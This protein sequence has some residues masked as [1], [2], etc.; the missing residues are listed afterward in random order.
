MLSIYT[1][2]YYGKHRGV[3][4]NWTV[5]MWYVLCK[6]IFMA[7][8][9][10]LKTYAGSNES[11]EIVNHTRPWLLLVNNRS[12]EMSRALIWSLLKGA[13]AHLMFNCIQN[14]NL[15]FYIYFRIKGHVFFQYELMYHNTQILFCMSKVH[16]EN[17][18]WN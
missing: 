4:K 8:P 11:N 15:T 6:S 5:K 10:S 1:L 2:R 18:V 7:L 14:F 9:E 3:V 17:R 16:I 12:W 13:F